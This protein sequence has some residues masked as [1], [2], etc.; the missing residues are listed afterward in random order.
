MKKVFYTLLSI[1]LCVF[2]VHA[3]TGMLENFNDNT[4]DPNWKSVPTGKFVFNESSGQLLITPSTVGPGWEN[5]EYSF[6]AID[7]SANPTVSL[8]IK[9]SAAFT[10][11]VDLVDN[12][13]K[14]TNNSPVTKSVAIN[15]SLT[16]VTLDFT[17][18]FTASGGATVDKTKISKIVF[19][20]NPGGTSY[21]SAVTFD[22][23]TVGDPIVST[24]GNIVLNQ[25]GYELNGTKTAIF[26]NS[27]NS[28]AATTFDILS[29]TNAV[30]YTG[31]IV[32]KGAVTGWTN[33]Y[34]WELNFSNFQTAGIY[35]IRVGTKVSYP[36]EIGQNILFSKTAFSVVD[37]FKGMRSTNNADK[38]LSFYGPR[39]DQVNV[40]GGWRDATGD[41]GKHMSH[42]SYA[43]YFNPQQIPFV[44][45]SLLKSYEM[46]TASFTAKSTDLLNESK[47]GADYLLRNIDKQQNYLYL[48]IFDDWGN[49]PSSREICEWGQAGTGNDGARTANYQAAMREGA[50]MAIAALSRAYRMNLNGDS[51]KTQY[52]NG[53]IR[54]YNNLKAPG[55]GYATK[56][57]EYCNDHTENIIDF[58]CGLL[59]TVELYKAT[60]NAAYLTDAS[61]YADKIISM[62]DP[63]GWFR[64]DVAG[65]R[66]FFH[67]ADEGLPLVSLMEYMDI[68]ASKNASITQVINK[69]ITWYMSISK[70]VNN[71]FNYIREYGK[72]YSSGTLGA[73][74]KAFFLPHNNETEYWWQGENARLASMSTALIM[75][76]RKLN[77]QFML[78][79]DT[80]STYGIAQLDWVLGKNP[81][82]VCMMTGAGT[83][84]YQN[85]P[86]ASAIPNV[87][88]GICNGITAK[89]MEETNIDWMPYASSDWQ[90]WRWIEQWLPHDAW[91]ILAVSAIDVAN[92]TPPVVTAAN[93]TAPSSICSG[94]AATITN[95]STGNITAYSWNFGSGA[96]I[97]TAAT[98]GPHSVSWSTGGTK[99][100]TL[101]V[102]GPDGN[103]T[104]TS[105]IVVNTVPTAAGPITGS[106]TVCASTGGV[107]YSIPAIATATSY[108]WVLPA[109]AAITA[110]DLT[111]SITTTYGTT[112]GTIQV[113]P[114]NSCGNGTAA[115]LAVTVNSKP[116]AAGTI[117]GNTSVCANATGITYSIPA[118]TT[119][120]SYNWTLPAGS[121]ITAGANSNAIT[122]TVG[123][124][125][126]DI[127]VTPVNTCGNGTPSTKTI[128][129][130]NV[131]TAAGTI[132]GAATSC[133]NAA[134]ITYSI[135]AITTATNYSWTV[136]AGT[137]ITAGANS[138]AITVTFGSTS[139]DI[140]VTPSNTCGNATPSSKTITLNS[141][142]AAAGTITGL[143]T[144][145]KN[146][147]GVTYSIPAIATAS[148][149]DWTLPAG[150]SIT[151]GATT[152]SITVTFATTGG[153]I[154]VTPVN[155]CGNG[156]PGSKTI[157]LNDIPADAGTITGV[158]TSCQNATGVSY[159]I[160]AIAAAASYNWTLPTGA[161]IT[162]GANTN[163]ITVSFATT[164][165]TIQVT[166]G[167]TCGNGAPSSK[168]ITLNTVPT[169]AGTITGNAA[170]CV[171]ATGVTYSIPAVATATS[172]DWIL[173]TGA[174]ITAGANTQ[175]I[176]VSFATTGGAIQV[177][178]VN[179]CGNGA[180]K[181]K[182]ITLNNVPTAAGTI[183]GLTEA[184]VNTTGVTYSI[185]AIATAT[186]YNW[187]LPTGA[188]ITTGANTRSITV[189]FATT[190]GMIQVTPV[191]TCGNGPAS[192][193]SITL[194]TIPAAAGAISGPATPCTGVAGINYSI[195]AIAA[196]TDYAWS[197][198]TGAVITGGTN[199]NSITITL[200]STGGTIQVIPSNSCGT[201]TAG[202]KTITLTTPP[203]AAGAISGSTSTCANSSG[204]TYSIATV[205]NATGYVW[206]IPAT[207]TITQGNNT[208]SITVT[209]STQ[210][211]TIQVAPT[212]TCGSG[213][214]SSQTVTVLPIGTS[215]CLL[216]ITSAITGPTTVTA[217]QQNV[218]YSV[219]NNNGSTYTWTVPAGATIISGQGTNTI[220]VSFGSTGGTVSVQETNEFGS[221]TAVSKDVTISTTTDI[222]AEEATATISIYPNPSTSC[223]IV[224]IKTQSAS[225]VEI[226]IIDVSG[227]ILQSL[228]CQSDENITIGTGLSA[229]VYIIQIKVNQQTS[230]HR[231]I[232]L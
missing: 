44:V 46:S 105:T 11:R 136:P 186:G 37:F 142:P 100:I 88:G 129:I 187:N 214:S 60:N 109:G 29:S 6:N 188:T 118:I 228:T 151:A 103:F 199:T 224:K 189:N 197:L 155:T 65:N 62:L 7:I 203:G 178:P 219:S 30:V 146:A 2:S 112:S 201:S 26:T 217:N 182:T 121:T 180:S 183:T 12:T 9:N 48:A 83:T 92:T 175:S 140:Q 231:L 150:A 55:T 125:T 198:P 232:K 52:L 45:W 143:I 130:N 192:S 181:S 77:A 196:A 4:L 34:F 25:V 108:S 81:F 98:A 117:T 87:T 61:A 85:Y 119:A 147:T 165:G 63:Q 191:N 208:N 221:G 184:C 43:N 168:T 99:T 149:Y 95:T 202:T 133:K 20:F 179:A 31:N 54:L 33:R 135:P 207:A 50:G 156:T 56:N 226:S 47:W 74:R 24:P 210:S 1:L 42:L 164:G 49:N 40:Y 213:A 68:D 171:N 172:Y 123:T 134:G 167:N 215:P 138:N 51:T 111:N 126:G 176:T 18:K 53:A 173:P 3:Q 57:L 70:E 67:A 82:D 216:P 141:V 96:S 89:D 8:K 227:L 218:T 161:T 97:A 107:T 200:G 185:P 21:S 59:A 194:N 206:E 15:S 211:G 157:T 127:Q 101:T 212:N 102:T 106:N 94:V 195:P 115:T 209:F 13:G 169:A 116:T 17:N 76:G 114:S 91:F 71:P 10:L 166:P 145:C 28:L 230:V 69:N 80:L 128:T 225:A 16:L 132:T 5:F 22:D 35:K 110:D 170:N 27:A 152:N 84:T 90:N 122:V 32:S 159:S 93:F 220:I 163:S 39:N 86:V 144:S 41:P 153:N 137:T 223:S 160:P 113:T 75:A 229:G 120:T 66:P 190:G 148:S 124:T 154:Q 14:A 177:T 193:T 23:V 204:I 36:F 174:S 64:S 78:G 139:G 131:P 73:A 19:F 158:A 58:Y 72:P 162:S 38:T 205:E 222:N 104:K 79:T